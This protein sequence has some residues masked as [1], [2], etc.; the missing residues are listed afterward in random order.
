MNRVTTRV[1]PLLAT[2]VAA[3]GLLL[4][5]CQPPPRAVKDASM[6]P[7]AAQFDPKTVGTIRG[8]VEWT[9]KLPAI[10]PI[11]LLLKTEGL[12]IDPPNP[13][14][15]R[16]DPKTMG[17]DQTLV[18]LLKVAPERSKPWSHADVE[19]AFEKSQ[20]VI[21]QGERQGR[22]GVVRRGAEIACVS[23]EKRNHVLLGRGA[24]VFSLSLIDMNAV[25]RRPLNDTGIVDLTSGTALF[26]LRG[27]LWVGEHPYASVTDAAGA[28]EMRDVPPGTYEIVSWSPNWRVVGSER[29]PEFG[30]IERLLFA[31]PVEQ[32]TSV[33]VRSGETATVDF[34]WDESLFN[35]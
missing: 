30:E 3:C 21:Q 35:K 33:V 10:E 15:P 24:S 16:I 17:M 19:V 20:L 23:R 32:K 13:N 7:L 4:P 14:A 2:L 8:R 6:T 12:A 22:L 9:G 28:F 18:Y 26:W 27:A 34:R 25:T 31:P 5:A 11:R 1:R 29:H